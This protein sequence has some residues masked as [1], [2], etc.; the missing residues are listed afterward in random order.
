MSFWLI[1]GIFPH[2]FGVVIAPRS[3]RKFLSSARFF[4]FP[5][6]FHHQPSTHSETHN[7][8]THYTTKGKGERGDSIPGNS[9]WRPNLKT[10]AYKKAV[11]L[12]VSSRGQ[13]RAR[14]AEQ[15]TSRAAE[16]TKAW[17]ACGSSA[18]LSK[19]GAGDWYTYCSKAS[20]HQRR[21]ACRE[22]S[23]AAAAHLPARTSATKAVTTTTTHSIFSS[24]VASRE[25]ACFEL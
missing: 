23:P 21:E 9:F 8:T 11:G 25:F 20:M 7:N 1:Y 3:G 16:C 5:T 17:V 19:G 6:L 22:G 10:R 14:H 2:N 18:Q 12:G 13:A 24:V 15:R 4:V